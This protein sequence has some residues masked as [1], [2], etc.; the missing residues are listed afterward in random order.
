MRAIA[1]TLRVKG[2]GINFEHQVPAADKLII[3]HVNLY[4]HARDPGRYLDDVTAYLAVSGP[5]VLNVVLKGVIGVIGHRAN[6][7]DIE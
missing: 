7:G 4:D 5:G 1:T 6:Q 2:F 3:H